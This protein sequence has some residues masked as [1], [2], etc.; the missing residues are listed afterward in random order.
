MWDGSRIIF[1]LTDWIWKASLKWSKISISFFDYTLEQFVKTPLNWNPICIFFWFCPLLLLFPFWG[2]FWSTVITF[3][4][5]HSS[6]W[7]RVEAAP[8][9]PGIQVSE[10]STVRQCVFVEHAGMYSFCVLHFGGTCV[11]LSF[12]TARRGSRRRSR[13]CWFSYH[14]VSLSVAPLSPWSSSSPLPSLFFFLFSKDNIWLGR[15]PPSKDSPGG[16]WFVNHTR[17]TRDVRHCEQ[18]LRVN[19]CDLVFTHS[20]STWNAFA[21]DL[22]MIVL[23]KQPIFFYLCVRASYFHFSNLDKHVSWF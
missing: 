14:G 2:M 21:W 20:C 3:I 9:P 16:F 18:Q 5:H 23:F 22:G 7:E 1:C 10:W 15:L 11:Q 17:S 13:I 6:F 4:W 8:R 12:C 19:V